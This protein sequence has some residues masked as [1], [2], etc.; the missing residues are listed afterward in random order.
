[1]F[2][3]SKKVSG[4]LRGPRSSVCVHVRRFPTGS[5]YYKTGKKASIHFADSSTALLLTPLSADVCVIGAGHAG[6]EAAAASARTGA[7][8]ILVTLFLKR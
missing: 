1:M 6:C 8:T 4:L 3:I 5:C 2:S 7:N